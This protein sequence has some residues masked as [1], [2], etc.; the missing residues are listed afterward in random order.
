VVVESFARLVRRQLG[1]GP[2]LIGSARPEPT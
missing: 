1:F 2:N